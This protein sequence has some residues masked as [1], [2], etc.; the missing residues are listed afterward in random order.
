VDENETEPSRNERRNLYAV[1]YKN[2]QVK[3]FTDD[4]SKFF[5]SRTYG[6]NNAGI[7]I[8]H[9]KTVVNGNTRT[10]FFHVDTNDF[11]SG[12]QMIMPDDFFKGSSSTARAINENGIIVGE[13]E[14]ETHND[15]Q[16]PRRRHA[17]MYEIASKTFTDL[18]DFLTCDSQYTIIEAR[19]INDK[20]EISA[21]ALV[22][23]PRRDAK[24]EL[25]FDL[26]TGEQLVEDVVRAVTLRPLA[27]EIDDCSAVEEKIEREGAG[28][29][30]ISLFA[31]LTFGFT[32]RVLK[33]S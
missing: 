22:K 1:V 26:D 19:D 16:S 21:S 25:M 6:I 20:N 12:M 13:G 18:N 11:D 30:F 29:G 5:D 28:L 15:Q 31:L 17:F 3:D 7:A 2:G 23:A 9:T 4:H 33:K 24:G 14:V 27:G 32:R 10:K 8:G